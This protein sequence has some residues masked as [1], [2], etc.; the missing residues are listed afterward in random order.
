MSQPD[1]PML[2]AKITSRHW[3]RWAYIYVRQ[4][5]PRQVERNRESQAYQYEM[6]RRAE[7]LGW[8]PDR[9]RIVDEDLGLSA[10]HSEH[11]DGFQE[12]VAEVSLGHVGIIFGYEVS[13][14]AR[15]NRDWYHLLDLAA[16]FATLIADADGVY[17]P[18]LYNDRLLLGLK[19]TMSEAELHLLRMRLQEGRLR[20]VRRGALQ[21][22][23]PTGLVRQ[24]DGTVDK[25][26]DRQIRDTI[27]L[28]L[29]KFEEL[30]SGRQVLLY[31]RREHLLLPARQPAGPHQGEVLWKP[32]TDAAIREILT[33]P[34]YAGAFVYGRRQTDPSRQHPGRP[35]TGLLHKPREEWLCVRQGAYPAYLSWEQYL[36]NQERLR[37]N[38][39]RFAANWPQ[40]QGAAREG[41]ALLQGLAACGLCGGAMRPQYK[42]AHRY[43]C[44]V[45]N[46]SLGE[47]MCASLHGPSID[48]VVVDAFFSA[49]RPAQLDALEAVLSA[50]QTERERLDRQWQE[51]LQRVR[52]EARLAERQ[53]QA[54]DPENRL[55]A[56]ELERRWE[57]Q[58]RQV[59]VAEEEYT[60]FQQQPSGPGLSPEL[61]RQLEHIAEELPELWSRPEFPVP[62]KKELLR[63]LISRVI[64]KRDSPDVVMVKIVWVS[65]HYT[66]VK[67]QAPILRNRSVTGYE[68]LAGRIQSLVARGLD[69]DEEIARQL[70][71]EGFHSARLSGVSATAVQKIRR[72]HGWYYAVPPVHRA[73]EREGKLSV[74]QLAEHLRVDRKWIYERLANGTIAAQYVHRDPQSRAWLIANDP[75]LIAS[76]RRLVSEASR[77]SER[78]CHG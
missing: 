37:Q 12:L 55:V 43:Q 49:I 36:A 67:A 76:L 66:E 44:D 18:R 70:T 27:E 16:L 64:L 41:A 63:C 11:R 45:R 42:S 75:G 5:S 60:R 8:T 54:V 3:E 50:Q 40:P 65:G 7:S 69:N 53:Y 19:G 62:H 78:H 14:L 29:T 9:I 25:H 21:Q 47:P 23:L 57:A 28:V 30:G 2:T 15:N 61:R 10:Q 71:R 32:P 68:A 74:T 52:Y 73:A 39:T 22:K 6:A 51:R 13:R 34:A 59:R 20:Q 17:D 56:A 35:A 4:S 26:P 31:C 77:D 48:A 46:R 58:L 24:P 33:N 1:P 38:S 72:A